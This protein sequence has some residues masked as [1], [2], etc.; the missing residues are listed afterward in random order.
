MKK[1]IVIG[2]FTLSGFVFVSCTADAEEIEIPN[3][4]QKGVVFLN[5]ND[6]LYLR[7]GDSIPAATATAVPP[8]ID[9]VDDGVIPP[10]KP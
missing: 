5:Q 8:V 10:K 2:L 1:I 6:G 3:H 4:Q 7:E 9:G